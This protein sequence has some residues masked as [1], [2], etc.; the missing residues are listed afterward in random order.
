MT[1]LLILAF[2]AGALTVAAPCI[3]P[4]L[5]V[6]IGGSLLRDDSD[7]PERQWLRPFVIALSLA[8][9]V[10]VF[11]L[12]IKATTALIGV[13][14]IVWQIISG[15][16]VLGLGIYFVWPHGW[17][18][19]SARS[20]LFTGSNRVLSRAYKQ[21]GLAGAVLI[22]AALGPVFSSCS[23]TYAFIVATVLPASFIQGFIYLV[24][25]AVGMSATLLSIAYI[26]QAFT[27]HL[28]RLSNPKSW[29]K[30][31][32]GVLFIVVGLMVIF[33]LDKKLQAYVLEQGWYDPV[34]NLERRLIN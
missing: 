32:I 21:K 23:P 22:G 6:I 16:I 31:V 18:V 24:A 28:R 10:I 33:G 34:A 8:A 19:L 25:Y 26:G 29:F 30:R 9:S 4:L 13:P 2:V 17:E 27:S 12:L 3:L 5:P 20:G 1:A 15:F 11:T 14:Q 7:K